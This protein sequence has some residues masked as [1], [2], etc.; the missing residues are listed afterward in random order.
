MSRIAGKEQFAELHRLEHE[1]SHTEDAL[2]GDWPHRQ[3]PVVGSCQSLPQLIEDPVIGPRR[4]VVV[5]RA[6]DI[7][8]LQLWRA[9]A[10][11]GKTAF[12]IGVDQFLGRRRGLHQD[13]EPAERVSARPF[14][15]QFD[16]DVPARDT[17]PSIATGDEI[18]VQVDRFPRVTETDD[19]CRRDIGELH[20]L[21][22]EQDVATLSEAGCSQVLQNLVLRIDRNG[23][24]GQGLKVDAMSLAGE[25]QPN[26]VVSKP[27]A[28]DAVTNLQIRHQID[29]GLLEHAR[30]NR[31]FDFVPAAAFEHNRVDPVSREQK[32]QRQ[33]CRAGPHNPYLRAFLHVEVSRRGTDVFDAKVAR[34][35]PSSSRLHSAVAV[36]SVAMTIAVCFCVALLEGFDIQALGISLGKLTTEFGLNG[37][38]RTLLTTF[39]SVGIV[40]RRIGAWLVGVFASAVLM[41]GVVAFC[42][43][44]LGMIAAPNFIALFVFRVLAGLGFGAAL[45]IMMAIAAEFST[46][47]RKA[48]TGAVILPACRRAAA[49]RTPGAGPGADFDWRSLFLIGGL[50]PFLVV[51]A[52]YFLLPETRA[53]ST[54]NQESPDDIAHALFN[55]GRL[56]TTLLMWATFLP[57]L[58]ILYLILNWLPT[59]MA[60]KG[61][62]GAVPAQAT[63]LFN[64]GSVGGALLFGRFVD[65]IGARWPLVFSYATLMLC[66]RALSRVTGAPAALTLSALTGFLL[67][68]ANY[69]LYGIA[70]AYYP[71]RVRGTGSGACVSVGRVGSILGPLLAG[72]WLSGGTAATQVIVYMAPFAAVAAL[73]VYTLGRYPHGE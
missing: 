28:T 20:V 33:A 65:R 71:K 41:R 26:P 22:V 54:V 50:L 25:T 2:L 23:A 62:G 1:A 44:T 58:T 40:C 4:D 24:S 19:W 34:Q 3:L 72:I 43:S 70:A 67:L 6:L 59:L 9:S 53:R 63:M 55:E 21:D 57:T 10:Y 69:A 45:P 18:T 60:A 42:P 14:V 7:E 27:L 30:S 39:S 29:C 38:Q 66:L 5:R 31:L 51:P 68:G 15:A 17:S 16:R 47:E 8:S 52:I 49:A 56:A 11:E 13:T 35:A 36:T 37:S 46:P 48:F 12:V 73:A 64:Y 61:F 32:R